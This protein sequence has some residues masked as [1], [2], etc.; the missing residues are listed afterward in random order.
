[1][2]VQ[3][4][5]SDQ[6]FSTMKAEDG[7]AAGVGLKAIGEA[8]LRTGGLI[9]ERQ[10]QPVI[11]QIRRQPVEVLRG[12]SLDAGEGMTLGL[13][14]YDADRLGVRVE[15]IVG[16]T[17]REWELTYGDA[18]RRRNVHLAVVLHRPARLVELAINA[19]ASRGF[20][21]LGHCRTWGAV[22]YRGRQPDWRLSR[23]GN[24]S[25]AVARAPNNA[26]NS[27][28]RTA[29]PTDVWPRVGRGGLPSRPRWSWRPTERALAT[30]GPK[31]SAFLCNN[32]VGTQ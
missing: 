21:R 29:E 7:P 26:L 18:R 2:I 20:W 17:R 24:P 19:L 1:M 32:L 10:R 6:F 11:R 16:V 12:L 4:D 31:Y 30:S 23:R 14:F 22:G 8:S 27:H 25:L 28:E 5:Q 3:I 9:G 15:Q 13:G